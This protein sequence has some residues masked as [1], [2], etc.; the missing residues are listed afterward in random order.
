M[1]FRLSVATML[2]LD[3]PPLIALLPEKLLERGT[4]AP[5]LLAHL[6]VSKYLFAG[7]QRDRNLGLDYL[8]ARYLSFNA[9]RFY[10][11]DVLIAEL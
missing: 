5:G 10:G 4:A 3:Q 2:D 1:F 11:R 7:E 8:R 9:G 6:I